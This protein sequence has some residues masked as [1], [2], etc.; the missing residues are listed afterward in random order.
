MIQK[1][2]VS[3]A[4]QFL[5]LTVISRTLNWSQVGELPWSLESISVNVDYAARYSINR[6][7]L[8]GIVHNWQMINCKVCA[9][10]RPYPC[11][12]IYHECG[13]PCNSK[14]QISDRSG[15][16]AAYHYPSHQSAA[17]NPKQPFEKPK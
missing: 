4:E 5:A 15:H 12:P 9:P 11:N 6:W 2:D 7:G 17:I 13:I 8:G 1:Y 14:I 3:G 16:T 10:V